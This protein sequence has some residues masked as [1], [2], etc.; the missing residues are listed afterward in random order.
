MTEFA[1]T[2]EQELRPAGMLEVDE[3]LVDNISALLEE[4]QQGMVLNMVADL[5]PADIAR[6]FEHLGMT[7]ARQLFQWMPVE[8]AG[9]VFAELD[10]DFR[11]TLAEDEPSERLT[12]LIDVL[13]TDDA[14]DVLADLDE[15]VALEVLPQ[16]E[17]ADDLRALLGYEEESAGGLMATEYVAVPLSW[18][19]AEATE[20]VRRNADEVDE[21]FVVFAIDDKGHLRGYV[22]LKDLLLSQSG[23]RIEEIMIPDVISV[24]TDLDQEEVARIMERY[25]LVSLPVVDA[26]ERLVGRITIDD[27]VDVIREEAE[28]D[29]QRMSGI[30][31]G[32]EHTD[33]VLRIT[34]GR[35]PWLVLGLVGAGLAGIVIMTFEETLSQV[36]AFA[37]FIPIVMAMAGNVGIQSSSIIVQGLAAGDVWTSDIMK[38]L[39]KEMTV[40]LLNGIVLALLLSLV[41]VAL[42][43]MSFFEADPLRLAL[44]AALALIAVI[45]LAAIIGTTVPLLLQRANI[46]PALAT[47]PFIT[48]SNDVLGLA[49]FFLLASL[50]YL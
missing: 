11:A 23:S 22:K 48:T 44:T 24:T 43:S 38:R 29:M 26:H 20:E 1:A 2:P 18:S 16:L 15:H 10:D 49:V 50:L 45:L 14:A 21:V 17:D 28:E 31:G 34:R 19:V 32:E 27:V 36:S 46:D 5:Y 30:T 47:G 9:K 4:E 3:E 12:A 41:V 39:I 37:F 7:D 35:L 33:S 6:L 13:D 25:D 42:V 40:A 8:Q